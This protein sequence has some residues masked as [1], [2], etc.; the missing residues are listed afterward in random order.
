MKLNG[1][2]LAASIG[3][4]VGVAIGSLLFP[5]EARLAVILGAAIGAMLGALILKGVDA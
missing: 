3:G 2:T 5:A 4:V 1:Q